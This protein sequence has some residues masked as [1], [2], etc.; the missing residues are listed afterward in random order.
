MIGSSR[1]DHFEAAAKYPNF[2]WLTD[3]DVV[4]QLSDRPGVTE[5]EGRDQHHRDLPQDHLPRCWR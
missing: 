5:R 1:Y 3:D 2:G 4:D